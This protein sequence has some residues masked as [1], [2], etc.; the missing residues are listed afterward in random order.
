MALGIL[1]AV[2]ARPAIFE[3]TEAVRRGQKQN[4]REVT[5]LLSNPG[6][7]LNELM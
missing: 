2:I 3:N 4:Q 5:Q 1:G 7:N 6:T